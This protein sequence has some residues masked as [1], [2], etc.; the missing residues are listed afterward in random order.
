MYVVRQSSHIERDLQRQWSSWNFGLEGFHGSYDELM[1]A[2]EEAEESGIPVEI[3]TFEYYSKPRNVQFGELYEN[4]WVVIDSNFTNTLACNI[5]EADTLEAAIELVY[6]NKVQP[7]GD[8]DMVDTS[9][10]KVVWSMG[11]IHI[12]YIED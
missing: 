2:F 12:L 10:A 4:Y 8:G 3:S 7:G 9:S 11:D 5:V 1:A 6:T